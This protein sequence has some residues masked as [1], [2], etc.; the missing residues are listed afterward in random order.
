MQGLKLAQITHMACYEPWASLVD[1]HSQKF[2]APQQT[3]LSSKYYQGVHALVLGDLSGKTCIEF[4]QSLSCLSDK[5]M[6]YLSQL[7]P[8]FIHTSYPAW[9]I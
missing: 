1:Q 4:I 5:C 9:Y 3:E 7:L 8:I 6:K 2:K